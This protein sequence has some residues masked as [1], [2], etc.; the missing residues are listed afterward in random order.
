M[1]VQENSGSSNVEAVVGWIEPEVLRSGNDTGV[2]TETIRAAAKEGPDSENGEN[3][4][5]FL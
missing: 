4:T 5:C 2:G 3:S 1:L